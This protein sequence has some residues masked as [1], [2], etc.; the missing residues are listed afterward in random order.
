MR[1]FSSER[2]LSN[3]SRL[4]GTRRQLR[5][6]PSNEA[7]AFDSS[8][9]EPFDQKTLTRLRDFFLYLFFPSLPRFF[10]ALLSQQAASLSFLVQNQQKQLEC[11]RLEL[12]LSLSLFTLPQIQYTK[13]RSLL[14]NSSKSGLLAASL[15]Q[16]LPL[17]PPFSGWKIHKLGMMEWCLI[18]L[19]TVILH[20][21]LSL[22]SDLLEWC[23]TWVFA[24][25]LCLSVASSIFDIFCLPQSSR[26]TLYSRLKSIPK[27]IFLFF[28][29]LLFRLHAS[30]PADTTIVGF[31]RTIFLSQTQ[32]LSHLLYMSHFFSQFSISSCISVQSNVDSIT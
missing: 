3:C 18:L 32:S 9:R 28:W 21:S 20:L 24:I 25:R 15:L 7:P 4:L 31:V 12:S 27:P 17:R 11:D 26:Q 6:T 16:I 5:F 29:H 14:F 13:Y 1:W 22:S 8:E 10:Y 2:L 19:W 23:G 30:F